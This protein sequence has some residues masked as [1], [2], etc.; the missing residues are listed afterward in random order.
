MQSSRKTQISAPTV[1][2]VA[3]SIGFQVNTMSS[4]LRWLM[5][6]AI[7]SVSQAHAARTVEFTTDEGTW[8]S[9]DVS[10]DGKTLVFD[11]L[12]RLYTLP[13]EG[14]RAQAIATPADSWDFCPRFSPDGSKLAFLSNRA[15]P[16][17]VWVMDR[18]TGEARQVSGPELWGDADREAYGF[19]CTARWVGDGSA[20]V[21]Q[22]YVRSGRSFVY[23]LSATGG[24]N[25]TVELASVEG[26]SRF[27]NTSVVPLN[28]KNKAIV[29]YRLIQEGDDRRDLFWLNLNDGKVNPLREAL[30]KGY[31]FN[32]ELSRSGRWLAYIRRAEKNSSALWLRDLK[33]GSEQR[34]TAL[35]DL[36]DFVHDTELPAFAFT[37]DERFIVISYGGKLHKVATDGS[38]DRVIPFEAKVSRP[39]AGLLRSEQRVEAGPVK[40]RAQRWPTL[41]ADRRTLAFSAGGS[42]WVRALPNGVPRAVGS[43]ATLN[44]MPALSP[45]GRELA[46][47]AFAHT[48]S[49]ISGPGRLMVQQIGSATAMPVMNDDASYYWPTWSPDR[50]KLAVVRRS[51]DGSDVQLGWIDLKQKT[52]HAVA[53]VEHYLAEDFRGGHPRWL[54]WSADGKKL[55]FQDFREW[56]AGYRAPLKL[57]EVQLD[58]TARRTLAQADLDVYAI[59]PAPDL[60]HAV[61]VGW[62]QNAYLVELGDLSSGTKQISLQMSGLQR[63]SSIGA[64]YPQWT[65]NDRFVYGWM[66]RVYEYRKGQAAPNEVAFTQ[67][68]LPRR[69]GQGLVAFRNGRLIT[70]QGAEGVGTVIEQGTLLMRDRHIVAVGKTDEVKVPA[71]AKVIDATGLTLMPGLVDTHYHGVDPETV[72]FY[73]PADASGGDRAMAFGIT[74]PF[75][76]GGGSLDD[77]AEDWRVLL[78]TGRIRGP[79]WR[80]DSVIDGTYLHPTNIRESLDQIRERFR[81]KRDLGQGPCIK[82]IADRDSLHSRWVA[83]AAREQGACVVAHVED[84]PFHSLARLSYGMALHHDTMPVPMHGDVVNYLLQA[85]VSW[86]PHMDL[87]WHIDLPDELQPR[88]TLPLLLKRLDVIMD[89]DDRTR[90][91]RFFKSVPRYKSLIE[92]NSKAPTDLY[93]RSRRP[94]FTAVANKLLKGGMHMSLSAHDRVGPLR[95]EMLVW[96]EGGISREHILRAATLGGAEQLG[97]QRDLGSLEPGKIADVLVLKANPLDDVLNTIRLKWT[98]IDGYIY[99]ST[100]LQ[101]VVPALQPR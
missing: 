26:T 30:A 24:A 59:V 71:D 63:V 89:L 4:I 52:F 40:L 69:Q 78:E 11:L 54:G 21:V 34:L 100:T 36:D 27:M 84:H 90:F 49:A 17:D 10:A 76:P 85:D 57:E 65:S 35:P 38:E 23:F 47:V 51:T 50:S 74:T 37:P 39:A 6:A 64:L 32:P 86:T 55:F 88:D 33:G 12:G 92:L 25:R 66:E 14:G 91:D 80:F 101:P 83:Q 45:D 16:T 7:F 56:K 67:L 22:D 48:P 41:S 13:I 19:P 87:E 9:V 94:G 72:A 58:G 93:S 73:L 99:D 98:V 20:L 3:L 82:E 31:A 96:Q 5:A 53:A 42:V 28:E 62:D 61:V 2:G 95:G 44:S 15:G 43:A 77:S 79:R 97:Y 68:S 70:M 8:M 46:Y 81:R 60:R 29:S 75:E 1:V 18:K